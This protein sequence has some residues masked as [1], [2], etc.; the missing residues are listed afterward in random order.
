M[1]L[2]SSRALTL[3]HPGLT[4][5]LLLGEVAPCTVPGHSAEKLDVLGTVWYGGWYV[6]LGQ[7]FLFSDPVEGVLDG[8]MLMMFVAIPGIL[9]ARNA[10]I[11]RHALTSL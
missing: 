6:P 7:G 2:W 4:S 8:A 3:C 10:T 11:T 1:L 9:A 5:H